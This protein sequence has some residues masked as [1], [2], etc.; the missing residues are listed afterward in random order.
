MQLGLGYNRLRRGA[1]AALAGLLTLPNIE[2]SAAEIRARAEQKRKAREVKKRQ[3]RMRAATQKMEEDARLGRSSN[4]PTVPEA[5]SINDQDEEARE[6]EGEL[7]ED[8]TS[9]SGIEMISQ[10]PIRLTSVDLYH[11]NGHDEPLR[12]R[13]ALFKHG[14]GLGSEGV[15]LLANALC[16]TSVPLVELNLWHVNMGS[17]GGAA[18]LARG[19]ERMRCP[20]RALRLAGNSLRNAGCEVICGALT[21]RCEHYNRQQLELEN[22]RAEIRSA[23]TASTTSATL[24]SPAASPVSEQHVGEQIAGANDMEQAEERGDHAEH[25]QRRK[26]PHTGAPLPPLPPLPKLPLRII[27]LSDNMIGAAGAAACASLLSACFRVVVVASAN[28]DYRGGE[29]TAYVGSLAMPIRTLLLHDNP[30]IGDAGATALALSVR[31]F[32]DPKPGSSGIRVCRSACQSGAQAPCRGSRA[33][34]RGGA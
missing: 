32:G 20:L 8:D 29:T 30:H 2:V 3:G 17:A 21:R 28:E 34:T 27:D 6:D 15:S 16:I 31:R 12:R 4:T 1:C 9:A 19:L 10:S 33:V 7:A 24:V 5:V 14:R 11:N 13:I 23:V 22:P 26:V 25:A 18:A